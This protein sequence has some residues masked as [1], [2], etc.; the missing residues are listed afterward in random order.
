MKEVLLNYMEDLFIDPNKL[1]LTPKSVIQKCECSVF[2]FAGDR[3]S[4]RQ[5]SRINEFHEE[6][7]V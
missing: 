7:F 3:E 6:N 4:L 1:I 5:H 2:Y